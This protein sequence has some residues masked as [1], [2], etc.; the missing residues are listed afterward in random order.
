MFGILVNIFSW[1]GF[2]LPFPKGN[3]KTAENI[4]KMH[5]FSF[6]YI[7]EGRGEYE[8]TDFLKICF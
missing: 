4:F 2:L 7:F 1:L 8:I 3:E 6:M 5:G